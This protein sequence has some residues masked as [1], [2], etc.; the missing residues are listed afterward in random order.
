MARPV[1]LACALMA[2]LATAPAELISLW[3][4]ETSL[5]ATAGPHAAE[6]GSGTAFSFH[7]DAAAVFS[8]PAGNGSAESFSA[9]R[10][11]V[12]D[13]FEFRLST[14]GYQDLQLSWDQARSSTGPA[15]FDL[16]YSIDGTAFTVALDDYAVSSASFSASRPNLAFT[17]KAD[18]THASALNNAADVWF[19]LIATTAATGSTGASRVDNFSVQGSRYIPRLYWMPPSGVTSAIWD[20]S[21]ANWSADLLAPDRTSYTSAH[22]AVFGADGTA[23]GARTVQIAS[24]GITVEGGVRFES[25]GFRVQGGTLTLAGTDA[26]ITVNTGGHVATIDAPLTG[27]HGLRKTGAGTLAINGANTF[28]GEIQLEGG[29]LSI[30]SNSALGAAANALMLKEG[31]LHVRGDVDIGPREITGSGT[32]AV[33]AGGRLKASGTVQAEQL[34]LAGG[35]I[36]FSGS[37]VSSVSTVI[38][39]P[40]TLHVPERLHIGSGGLAVRQSVGTTRIEGGI[41]LLGASRIIDVADGSTDHDLIIADS[42]RSSTGS[43]QY[44]LHKTGPGT[45]V[46]QAEGLGNV[47]LRIGT[48]GSSSSAVNG[49]RVVIHDSRALGGGPLDLNY[50]VLEIASEAS[51]TGPS[52]AL[53][54]VSLG[55]VEGGGAAEIRGGNIEF[56]GDFGLYKPSGAKIDHTLALHNHT[57]LSGAFRH[58]NSPATGT[59]SGLRL[60]GSGTLSLRASHNDYQDPLIVD[61]PALE[62]DGALSASS[63]QVLRGTLAGTTYPGVQGIEGPL[64]IGDDREGDAILSPGPAFLRDGQD[65]IGTLV[66]GSLTLLS[67]A[68]LAIDLHSGFLLSDQLT[69]T[70]GS[71]SISAGARLVLRDL[72]DSILPEG[73]EF[74]LLT[75]DSALP[76]DGSFDQ[77]AWA[78]GANFFEVSY[79]GGDGNDV[80]LRVIPEP[81]LGMLLLAGSLLLQTVSRSRRRRRGSVLGQRRICL[82]RD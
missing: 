64:T 68:V 5:P 63:V 65:G 66:I 29:T 57:I 78:S 53:V 6:V 49:G 40:T 37:E 23:T 2:L 22:A 36:H 25:D 44:K 11:K 51:L 54:D 62:V 34:V 50:G 67:D 58:T 31:G 73:A 77:T 45:L 52:S 71:L 4:F 82:H 48:A 81:R 16:A 61:G 32:I 18:L 10:W 28:T 17:L 7:A 15:T 24:S 76:V 70:D 19:R 26:A 35:E 13:Y 3:T 55:G 80:V 43:N 79:T 21:T 30:G 27:T 69:L 41:E 1:R 74:T 72:G 14:I 60:T 9:N 75:I 39:A 56:L 20:H 33:E 47:G 46:L 42:Y 59:F 38:T 8:N 12:G